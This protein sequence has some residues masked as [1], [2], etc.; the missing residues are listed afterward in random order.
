MIIFVVSVG[1]LCIL[2]S[3]MLTLLIVWMKEDDVKWE[4]KKIYL[5]LDDKK[6]VSE[7]SSDALSKE[8]T[9]EKDPK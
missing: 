2:V 8:E 7:A 5:L 4:I 9:N 6:E 3:L 1:V